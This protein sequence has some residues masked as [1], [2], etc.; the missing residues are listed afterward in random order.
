MKIHYRDACLLCQ[1]I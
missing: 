1:D